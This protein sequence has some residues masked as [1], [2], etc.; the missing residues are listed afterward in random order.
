M[1]IPTLD[2]MITSNCNLGCKYC[3]LREME[4][5]EGFITKID[6]DFIDGI[7]NSKYNLG[8]FMFGGEPLL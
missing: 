6:D 2:L 4:Q 3:F 5:S 8:F 7:V 1:F